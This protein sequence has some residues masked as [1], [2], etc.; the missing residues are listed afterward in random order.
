MVRIAANFI[1]LGMLLFG[2]AL[3]A[4][5]STSEVRYVAMENNCSPK[6]IEVYNQK[7][8]DQAEITYLVECNLPKTVDETAKT[9]SAILIRCRYNLCA[10]VRPQMDKKQ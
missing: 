4:H 6:K 2:G 9:P 5:A 7:V 1:A 8:G 10:F 3:T